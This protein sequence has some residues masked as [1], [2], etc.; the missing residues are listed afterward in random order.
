MSLLVGPSS[1][2]AVPKSMT[3]THD[4]IRP[5]PFLPTIRVE[6]RAFDELVDLSSDLM[7]PAGEILVRPYTDHYEILFGREYYDAYKE[8][9]PKGKIPVSACHYA[10]EE[11]VFQTIKLYSSHV[12]LDPI[13][14]AEVYERAINHFKWRRSVL[15][16][17][18]GIQRSTVTNRLELLKLASDV[19]DY[20]REG[21]LTIEHGKTLSRLDHTE[22]VRLGK[23]A[24]R[25]GWD[26]RTLYKKVHPEWKPKGGVSVGHELEPAIEKDQQLL[27]LESELSDQ[28]G[29]PLSLNVEKRKGYK[30][31]IEVKFFGL[32]ELA[33][34]IERVE[35]A[36]QDDGRWKGK[37][38][39]EVSD[40]DHLN[41]I[42]GDLNPEDDF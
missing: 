10:D 18:V 11:A 1:T 14:I 17:A 21:K 32:G 41:D 7:A 22:Q 6:A 37:I 42:L 15:A 12:D 34:F 28:L 25:H 31:Q 24:V 8:A 38:C 3:L 4:M 13:T 29:A 5:A 9:L 19:K 35:R 30:G 23:L 27:S 20:V 26:T 16:R 2:G 36:S 40:M 39:L 33:G